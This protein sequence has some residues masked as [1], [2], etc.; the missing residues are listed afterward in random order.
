MFTGVSNRYLTDGELLLLTSK[1]PIF[2]CVIKSKCVKKSYPAS[3]YAEAATN[4]NS[5]P[6][7]L[8]LRLFHRSPANLVN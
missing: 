8:F 3:S 5:Q 4:P 6:S 7:R 1:K 2:Y